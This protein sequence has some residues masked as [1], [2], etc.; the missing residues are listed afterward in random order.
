[1]DNGSVFFL[2]ESCQVIG[3]VTYSLIRRAGKDTT[4][5]T[6]GIALQV[7]MR[8]GTFA[9]TNN[10]RDLFES[11]PN[12]HVLRVETNELSVLRAKLW[13]RLQTIPEMP[14]VFA[15]T[16]AMK[17]WLDDMQ[18][19]TFEFR[20]RTGRFARMTEYE[21]EQAVRQ[22]PPERQGGHVPH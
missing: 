1:L 13:E 19:E 15:N 9:I 17:S 11:P 5:A 20:V 2:D 3:L 10:L 18:R 21:V 4:Q 14:A 6:L 12:H 8:R 16:E 22:L 7:A